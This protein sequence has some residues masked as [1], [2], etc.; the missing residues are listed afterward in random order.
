MHIGRQHRHWHP[1]PT[2]IYFKIAIR[3]D[4]NAGTII[5]IAPI[6]EFNSAG[7]VY[8]LHVLQQVHEQIEIRL[9]TLVLSDAAAQFNVT[10]LVF[11][12]RHSTQRASNRIKFMGKFGGLRKMFPFTQRVP[13]SAIILLLFCSLRCVRVCVCVYRKHCVGAI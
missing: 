5:Q 10:I 3:E 11:S 4:E 13:A 12:V 7:S 2:N 9:L 8:M 1:R 6:L